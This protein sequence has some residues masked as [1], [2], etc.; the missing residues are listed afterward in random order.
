[1]MRAQLR[2]IAPGA[3]CGMVM[4]AALARGINLRKIDTGTVGVSLD[5]TVTVS[6]LGDLLAAFAPAGASA[7]SVDSLWRAATQGIDAALLR[8][9]ATGGSLSARW[10]L[11]QRM[12]Q[13]KAIR[14]QVEREMKEKAAAKAAA[15]SSLSARRSSRSASR[16]AV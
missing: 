12:E 10:T 16:D 6:D 1:M 15:T 8:G 2:K 13:E 9:I 11:A 3:L 14:E 4:A 5:E 7:P